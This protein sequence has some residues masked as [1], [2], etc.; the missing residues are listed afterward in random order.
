MPII[1]DP[2]SAQ[3]S[4]QIRVDKHIVIT[5][6][7]NM[8]I[9]LEQLNINPDDTIRRPAA[10]ANFVNISASQIHRSDHMMTPINRYPSWPEK[11]SGNGNHSALADSMVVTPSFP[12]AVVSASNIIPTRRYAAME[13]NT[14]M[15]SYT[16]VAVLFFVAMMITWIP[17]SANRVYS[18]V[19]KN[20]VSLPLEYISATV[21][22]LQGFWNAAIYTITSWPACKALWKQLRSGKRMSGGGLRT[23]AAAFSSEGDKQAYRNSRVGGNRVDKYNFESE[24]VTELHLSRSPTGRTT[25]RP[26]TDNSH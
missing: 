13:A 2:F 12:P 19:N 20:Q 16:K 9:D 5:E 1:H 25:E 22:P 4:T 11:V 26:S 15:Y 10:T 17:S 21:L 6:S 18:V 7:E 3:Q 14:A 24:S 23:M 8:D